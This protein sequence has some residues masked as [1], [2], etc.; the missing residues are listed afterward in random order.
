MGK[1]LIEIEDSVAEA[2]LAPEQYVV[3]AELSGIDR[4][5]LRAL[6]AQ[7]NELNKQR[8]DLFGKI[9]KLWEARTE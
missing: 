9:D 4:A 1:L 5:E 8:K 6:Y 2:E 3:Y 7:M